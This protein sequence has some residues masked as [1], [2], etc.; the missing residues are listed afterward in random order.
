MKR[1]NLLLCSFVLLLFACSFSLCKKK[2]TAPEEQ[3]Q[4]PPDNNGGDEPDD[5][6]DIVYTLDAPKVRPLPVVTQEEWESGSRT[7]GDHTQHMQGLAYS[8]SDPDRIYMGQDV[9][10]VW[11]SR[12]FGLSWFT[13]KCRGLGSHFVLSIEVDP[14]DKNRIM[15]AVN[16]RPYDVTN[17]EYQG[18]YLS[19]DGGITWK[20]TATRT[21]LSAVRSSTKMLAYAP[22]SK[23]A[24]KGYATRWYAAFCEGDAGASDDGLL[25]SND[26]GETWTEVMKLPAATFGEDIRGLK[27]HKTKQEKVFLY[28]SEGLFRFED[29]ANPNGAVTKISGRLAGAPGDLPNGDIKGSIYQSDDGQT[30]M[31]AVAQKGIYKST[32]AGG[33]WDL[34]Y[35]WDEIAYCYVNEKYPN[36]IFAVPRAKNGEQ[37]RISNDGGTSWYSPAKSDVHYRPGYDNSDWVRKLNG[38]FTYILSDPRDPQK[39]FIHTNS[40]NFRT[41]DGGHTWDISDNGFNAAQHVGPW[42]EQMFDP[43]NPDRFCYFMVDRSY[44]YTD[45]RGRWFYPST[46]Q[47]GPLGLNGRTCLSG[48]LHPTEPVILASV[49]TSPVGQLLR[50][51]DNGKTWSVVSTGNKQRWCIAFNL[52]HPD[53]CY[54]WRERSID[55]GQTWTEML[56]MPANAILCAVSRSNGRVLYAMDFKNTGKKI[57]RSTDAGATWEQ[58]IEAGWKMT[59]PGDPT[60]T[61]RVHPKDPNIVYTYSASGYITRWDVTTLPAKATGI[62]ITGGTDKDFFAAKFAIDPR[63][64]KVMYAINMRAN[65]GNKFF[66]TIDEGATWQNISDYITEGSVNGLAVS[67]VSGEVYISGENG[68]SVM[69]PPYA[70]SN[71]AYDAVPYTSN[72]LLAPYN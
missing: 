61:I 10:N 18:I 57:W 32:N 52:Q 25:T 41:E 51:P 62:T 64:P 44:A 26:G 6:D 33:K 55:A 47:P 14:L 70:T 24:Q 56:N 9:S 20:W 71:T 21:D 48:A 58:V 7:P 15:A 40:K 42:Q 28:G 38:Q 11:V 50:S 29:A 23:D 49:G 13:P 63:H 45:T 5:E 66:R 27:V 36:M 12:D 4:T 22:T 1:F 65:T 19:K 54:Q 31:V 34:L 3:E 8:E 17:K 67:P 68:S 46:I 72:I 35:P 59:T 43:V 37:I 60:G 69:L 30:L 16:C 53:T 39:A 2:I